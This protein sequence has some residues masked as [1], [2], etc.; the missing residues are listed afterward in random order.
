[1]DAKSVRVARHAM[2]TRFEIL[3]CGDNEPALRAA[4]EEALAEIER[5]EQ[6]LSLFRPDSEISKI[7]NRAAHDPVRVE[8]GLF[9]LLEICRDLWARSGESF[10]ITV[11]PLMHC[12]GFRTP[13][14]TPPNPEELAA[15]RENVGMRHVNLNSLNRTVS[16]DRE[17]V[18]LDLGGIAKGWAL[19]QA[20]SLLRE[21]GVE[22]ALLHGGTS[23]SCA[24][25]TSPNPDSNG[26]TIAIRPPPPEALPGKRPWPEEFIRTMVLRDE[27]LS[28][29]SVAGR[30]LQRGDELEG[31][32]FDP[33]RGIPV[34]EGFLAAVI[35]P[36]ATESDAFSTALLAAGR[37]LQE[38]LTKSTPDLRSLLLTLEEKE[39]TED[40][41][42]KTRGF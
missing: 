10:D 1:M 30:F 33:R 17:G 28:V 16:F 39:N 20:A 15:V 37:S 21:A 19:D 24:L 42:L 25:G 9:R 12:W 27:A 40:L 35:L 7:N 26:W 23:T 32:V 11:G 31:H 5:L 29:S 8:P 22:N 6:Q 13:R 34:R 36:S 38:G 3:L 2:G 18:A 14:A 41:R 4:G